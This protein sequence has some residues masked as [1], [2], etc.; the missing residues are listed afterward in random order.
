M[1]HRHHE[2]REAKPSA[3]FRG[4][5][6]PLGVFHESLDGR[7]SIRIVFQSEAATDLSMPISRRCM[8]GWTLCVNGRISFTVFARM[9]ALRFPDFNWIITIDTHADH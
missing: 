4:A 6:I 3:T 1:L 7:A 5:A 2:Y 9:D 8:V